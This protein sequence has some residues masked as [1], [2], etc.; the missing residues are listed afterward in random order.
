[1]CAGGIYLTGGVIEALTGHLASDGCKFLE[2]MG[3]KGRLSD[4]IQ[5]VPVSMFAKNPGLDGAE[6]F[7]LQNFVH[8][9]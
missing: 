9:Q 8:P 6:Q 2:I 5:K 4:F 7:G 3:N 1:M